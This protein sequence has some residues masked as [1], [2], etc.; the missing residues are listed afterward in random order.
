M[1]AIS[2]LNRTLAIRIDA[3][4]SPEYPRAIGALD[5][6]ESGIF[7]QILRVPKGEKPGGMKK[8]EKS[9]NLKVASRK[10]P[11]FFCGV[12]IVELS[13]HF[14][15]VEP[16][17]RILWVPLQTDDLFAGVKKGAV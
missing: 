17:R 2:A 15:A 7:L 5:R 9:K 8:H 1:S 14:Q 13:F 11:G 12:W 16:F 6:P 3:L 4:N 10:K